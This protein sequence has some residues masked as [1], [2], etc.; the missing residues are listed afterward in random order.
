MVDQTYFNQTLP[1]IT[2]PS[3][4]EF[5]KNLLKRRSFK[6]KLD[7]EVKSVDIAPKINRSVYKPLDGIHYEGIAFMK[8]CR[9]IRCKVSLN[10]KSRNGFLT[11]HKLRQ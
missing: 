2:V 8:D 6:F 10:F 9:P 4:A 5:N 1:L 3:K 7:Q 11:F